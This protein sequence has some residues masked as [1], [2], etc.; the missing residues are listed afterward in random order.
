M[1]V[2]K[3]CL[4]QWSL[5]EYLHNYILRKKI[6]AVVTLDTALWERLGK[7]ADTIFTCPLI[8][9]HAFW[10]VIRPSDW[11]SYPLIGHNAF[12]L[13]IRGL[14]DL[15]LT[16]NLQFKLQ[17]KFSEIKF[18][19][20]DFNSFFL[21]VLCSLLR[22]LIC[23]PC[24]IVHFVPLLSSDILRRWE[25]GS[26]LAAANICLCAEQRA[27]H[28]FS[29]TEHYF[30]IKLWIKALEMIWLQSDCR[31]ILLDSYL[32]KISIARSR[33]PRPPAITGD[34][35]RSPAITRDHPHVLVS[36]KS[37]PEG[38]NW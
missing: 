23:V 30:I 1:Y 18:L 20:S 16:I 15:G 11:E 37:L 13:T 4:D 38:Q 21:C 22:D 2:C 12:W 9:N 34:N 10:L 26:A 3:F 14:G 35:W 27:E 32:E 29:I 33:V 5:P 17:L 24:L 19:F 25:T 36:E 8:G 31:I 28:G 6:K 7:Q